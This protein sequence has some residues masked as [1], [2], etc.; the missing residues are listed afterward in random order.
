[1]SVIG[2]GGYGLIVSDGDTVTKMLYADKCKDA[3][4]EYAIQQRLH[5][6]MPMV[7]PK[8]LAYSGT[9]GVWE[10]AGMRVNYACQITMQRLYPPPGFDVLVHCMAEDDDP[11]YNKEMF[12]EASGG[13]VSRGYFA[14]IDV[15]SRFMPIAELRHRMGEVYGKCIDAGVIPYDAEF[16]LGRLTPHGQTR[17]FLIDFGMALST[18]GHSV[19]DAINGVGSVVGLDLDPYLPNEDAG[20]IRGIDTHSPGLRGEIARAL[21]RPF[22]P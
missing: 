16:V 22:F 11:I 12:T 9:A 14:S 3:H 6:A 10:G 4:A 2:S 15:L 18:K 7:V 5:A 17:L 13:R 1:M 20:F 8:P 19:S 21:T